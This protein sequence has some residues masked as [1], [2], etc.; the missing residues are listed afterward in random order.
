VGDRCTN[1]KFQKSQFAPVEVFKTEKKGL[2]LRAAANI[3]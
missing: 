2:G 3:P 1:K